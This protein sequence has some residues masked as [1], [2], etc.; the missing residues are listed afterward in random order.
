MSQD[1][2]GGKAGYPVQ[3]LP[4]FLVLIVC[5]CRRWQ[6]TSAQ[7]DLPGPTVEAPQVKPAA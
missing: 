1:G 7:Q 2:Y 4:E 5:P 6:S 3:L